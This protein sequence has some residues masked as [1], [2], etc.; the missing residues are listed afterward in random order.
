MNHR[1]GERIDLDMPVTVYAADLGRIPGRMVNLSLSGAGI[2]CRCDLFEI[3]SVVELAL[4]PDD[5]DQGRPIRIEGFVVRIRDGLIGVM[6]MRDRI[7]L[8]HRLS[9]GPGAVRGFERPD[10]QAR[11]RHQD[12]A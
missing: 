3:Y 12:I 6:F 1:M 10:Y 7:S 9:A 2:Y 11:K 4:L 5:G 8:V